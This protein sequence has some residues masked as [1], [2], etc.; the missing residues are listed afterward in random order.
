MHRNGNS[1]LCVKSILLEPDSFKLFFIEAPV[2][3]L[4]ISAKEQMAI[5]FHSSV[6]TKQQCRNFTSDALLGIKRN[7]A[8]QIAD[9]KG[10]RRHGLQFSKR[11]E[12]TLSWEEITHHDSQQY[13]YKVKFSDL[14]V[15]L[16]LF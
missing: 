14:W 6:H 15:A 2:R 12:A 11:N 1:P 7:K 9:G 8:N 16:V 4:F 3:R 13:F 10:K 5:K